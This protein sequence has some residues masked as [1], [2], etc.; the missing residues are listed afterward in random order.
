MLPLLSAAFELF[1]SA[2]APDRCA[3]CDVRVPMLTAFCPVCAL[4]LVRAPPGD[5]S[6]SAP[7]LYG[8]ALAR[9]IT[10]MKYERRPDLARQLAAVAV[11]GLGSL[12]G[13]RPDIVV[14]VP[15]HPSRL[16]ERGFNQASLLARPIARALGV[17]LTTGALVRVRDTTQQATLD[18]DARARNVVQAFAVRTP[19]A[20]ADKHVLLVDDVRTTGATL[21]A[22]ADA[23][24]EAGAS[25]VESAVVARADRT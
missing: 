14:P 8:G 16:V 25:E 17:P 7:Y 22:C 4:T 2:L 3:A 13:G 12:P 15:L 18:R 9:A 19:E 23:L 10:R 21:R 20:V 5:P 24:H 1:A 11:R 6:L